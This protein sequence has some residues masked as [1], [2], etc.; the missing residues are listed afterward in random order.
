MSEKLVDVVNQNNVL[1]GQAVPLVEA[2][3]KGYWHRTVHVYV[4]RRRGDT[5]EFLTH[6]RS[7]EKRFNP[8]LWDTRFGSHIPAGGDIKSTIE[9]GVRKEFG[10]QVATHALIVGE[11][12][13]RDNFPN[14]EFTHICFFELD[15]DVNSLKLNAREV[16]E[17]RWRTIDEIRE[18]MQ[19]TPEIWSSG[20]NRFNEVSEY[21][22]QKIAL[23]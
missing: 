10:V 11:L 17:V 22:L 16:Q 1:V 6:L 20:L 18:S 4:Y 5:V 21:L 2:H 14:R 23:P 9:S 12:R 19:I 7:K 8:N 13:K 15:D 3:T